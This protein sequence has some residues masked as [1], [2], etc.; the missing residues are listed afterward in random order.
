MQPSC[1]TCTPVL[2][3]G[4]CFT[5]GGGVCVDDPAACP[6]GSSGF[7]WEPSGCP[8]ADAGV[9][10]VRIPADAALVSR[11]DASAEP[12]AV[13]PPPADDAS[14]DAAVDGADGG[15]DGE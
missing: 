14:V 2:G 4:F 10:V 5:A 9:D 15:P 3:C 8:G 12:D 11:E 6:R 1:G 7:T 13:A